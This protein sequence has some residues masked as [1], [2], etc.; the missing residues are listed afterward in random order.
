MAE[1]PSYEELE[2]RVKALEQADFEQ[3]QAKESLRKSEKRF[4]RIYESFIDLYYQTDM[5]GI[6]TEL[7][8]SVY[9]ITGWNAD[10]LIG[11][12]VQNVYVNPQNRERLISKL[13][14]D[15][16]ITG[17]ETV[18]KKKS[19]VHIPV[20]IN[21]CLIFDDE[22]NP[23]GVAGTVRDITERKQAEARLRQSEERLKL[24]FSQSLDGFFFMMLD[25]PIYWNDTVDKEEM[26]DY[27][28]DHQ[29]ITK[30]NDAMLAQYGAAR[31]QFIGRTFGDFFAHDIDYGKKVLREFF[32][33]GHLHLDTDE[34]KIDDTPIWIEGDYVCMYD[35][36]RRITGY[37]GIQRDITERRKMEMTLRQRESYLSAIIEN[38]PGLIWLKD[39]NSRFLSVNQAFAISCGKQHVEEVVG[40]TDFDV[41][42]QELAEKYRKDD[43]RIMET[44]KSAII[45]EPIC[46]KGEIRWF[47]TFK[48]PIFNEHRKIIGT[49]GYARDITE[50]KK[51]EEK[52][53]SSEENFRTFF[54]T[55]DDMIFIAN[56]QGEI[57]Y[58]NSAVARKLGYSEEESKKLYVLDFH[59]KNMRTE[60]TQIF[61]DM[62]GKKRDS[63]PL[64]LVHKNGSLVPVETRVWFG[65]WN[66]KECVFGISKDLSKEQEALQKF[67]R[68]FENNPALMAVSRVPERLF[69]EV[70]NTFIQKTG[71]SRDELIGRSSAD[72]NLFV[73]S[74]KHNL[75]AE[76][77]EKKGK[78]DNC[79][80][81]I[82]T[83]TGEILEGLFAGVSIESQEKKYFLTVM[84]DI[85]EQK[86]LT[87]TVEEQKNRLENVIEGTRLGTWEW[88]IQTGAC[89]I[90][91]RWADII[92]YT[93][94]ELQP[95]SIKIWMEHI[96]F[97]DLQKSKK[98]LQKHFSGESSY[99]ELE[100]RIK[101][102]N[103]N[104]IWIL[105]RGKVIEWDSNNKPLRMFGTQFDITEKKEAEEKIRELLIRDPLT[106]AYNR[107]YL[108]ERI[109]TLPSEYIR[110]GKMF[111]I[112]ILDIDLFKNINDK[113]G[114]LAGDFILKELTR[115]ISSNL[116]PYDVLARYG[117]EEFMIVLMNV[118]KEIAEWIMERIAYIIRKEKFIYNNIVMQIT[119]SCGISD[120]T[121]YD[122]DN[123]SVDK[124]I[125]KAD[126]R[127]YLA[128]DT[129]R[130]KIVFQS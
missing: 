19:G 130:N 88:N 56:M 27:I 58:T 7:S 32:D 75:I 47:E 26:I 85:T 39:E 79:E 105:N 82:I 71:Y 15:G 120:C 8:P 41:W 3:K 92:G 109:E 48:T 128:K 65:R 114:H 93:I 110:Y 53:K 108:F 59:H 20:S 100:C 4:R 57:F 10:E 69:S 117:G 129:G 12:P 55:M 70:N 112:A 50:R 1:K 44:G 116:R 31:E 68:L 89:I 60:A 54:E 87:K 73:D 111:S 118:N 16:I 21:A 91:E 121:E 38:Q 83:K 124:L 23:E 13:R 86:K 24:F 95:V 9:S 62:L 34:R 42:T 66:D 14:T 52:L 35:S 61:A 84:V 43:F 63:C 98:L 81:Q 104:W 96:H 94:D 78:V 80:L 28:F 72:L 119:F 126:N 103:G 18:L 67:N 22:G 30:V 64:P 102:K 77:L 115:I 122:K 46:D 51:I 99:Y 107:R 40:K 101:H 125:E 113:Y 37:F 5:N 123:I 25:E 97:N 11:T 6:I 45:E 90:N 106:N 2:Q 49:T 29:R 36:D 17:F 74:E 33:A 76:E 127:L